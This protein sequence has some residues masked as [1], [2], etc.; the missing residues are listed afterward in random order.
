M[1]TL[2]YWED[3]RKLLFYGE[4]RR[5]VILWGYMNPR[6][7][8]RYSGQMI[9]ERPPESLEW[10]TGL[11][12]GLRSSRQTYVSRVEGQWRG[13]RH[14]HRE[15][16]KRDYFRWLARRDKDIAYVVRLVKRLTYIEERVTVLRNVS[17]YDH[18]RRGGLDL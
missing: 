4:E 8:S 3:E 14:K 7:F 9:A 11:L 13:L 2:V 6:Q 5:L 18:L 1:K 10:L 17:V 15:R 12:T 16:I